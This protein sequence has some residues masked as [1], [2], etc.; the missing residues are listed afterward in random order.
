M[1][2]RRMRRRKKTKTIDF[3]LRYVCLYFV[4]D[5]YLLPRCQHNISLPSQPAPFSAGLLER[6]PKVLIGQSGGLSIG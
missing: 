3:S 1:K 2:R 4:H 6:Y 5:V